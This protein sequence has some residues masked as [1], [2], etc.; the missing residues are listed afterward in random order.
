MLTT[1]NYDGL[2]FNTRSRTVQQNIKEQLIPQPNAVTVTPDI[3]T[4][5]DTPDVMPKPFTEDRLTHPTTDSHSA[6]ASPNI[7]QME[8]PQSMRLISFSMSKDYY[9]NI[10]QIQTRNSWPLSYQKLGSTQC[11]WKHM[12][13]PFTKELLTHTAS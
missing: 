5:K 11:S 9:I 8:K 1:T 13:N 10:S 7:N 3:T 4:V 6:S 12:T 2:A